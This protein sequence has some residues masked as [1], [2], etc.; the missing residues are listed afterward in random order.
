LHPGGIL[1]PLARHLAKEEMMAAGWID[2]EGNPVNNAS[3]TFKTPQEGAAISPQL[4][5]LGGVYCEDCDIA[6]PAPDDSAAFRGVRAY[7]TDP[8]QA[9]RLWKLSAELTGVNAFATAA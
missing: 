6:E 1:T 4:D 8:E 3:F 5:G 7:A 2:E 9:A